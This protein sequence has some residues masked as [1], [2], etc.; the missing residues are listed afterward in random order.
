MLITPY[1]QWKTTSNSSDPI[2][3][4]FAHQRI[5]L[6][7]PQYILQKFRIV[8]VYRRRKTCGQE[9]DVQ[10]SKLYMLLLPRIVKSEY[11]QTI[12]ERILSS[13]CIRSCSYQLQRTPFH[14]KIIQKH[15]F[16]MVFDSTRPFSLVF[17]SRCSFYGLSHALKLNQ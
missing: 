16:C 1:P 9:L 14:S 2:I 11:P 17:L 3:S 12:T 10:K 7:L 15:L 4:S 8:F 5:T 13:S 6:L